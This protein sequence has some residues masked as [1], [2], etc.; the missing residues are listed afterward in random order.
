MLSKVDANTLDYGNQNNA[1]SK[2]VLQKISSENNFKND[3]D[4][5]F[6]HLM[7][8]IINQSH[9]SW[10]GTKCNGYIKVLSFKPFYVIL[11]TERQLQLLVKLLGEVKLIFLYF[12]ATGTLIACQPGLDGPIYICVARL[13]GEKDAMLLPIAEFISGVHDI[14]F[15]SL[16]LKA[17]CQTLR[18]MTTIRLIVHKIETDYGIALIQPRIRALNEMSITACLNLTKIIMR[19]KL[20]NA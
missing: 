10:L 13:P 6:Y 20:D 14:T 1:L 12:D 4:P 15:I 8:K 5:N 2:I 9:A 18:D 16:F 7:E 3:L 17:L 19:K 11:F